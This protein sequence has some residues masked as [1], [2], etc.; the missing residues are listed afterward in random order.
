MLHFKAFLLLLL[1]V[2]GGAVAAKFPCTKHGKD[3]KWRWQRQPWMNHGSFRGN[4]RGRLVDP[5]AESSFQIPK[6]PV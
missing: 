5:A 2:F 6:F 1:L 3:A 4:S